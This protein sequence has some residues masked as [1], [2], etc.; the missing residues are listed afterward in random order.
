MNSK[1]INLTQGSAEWLDFRKTKITATD[2][3]IIMGLNPWKTPL[4]LWEEKL[5]LR[6]PQVI[7]DKMRDGSLMEEEARNYIN[8]A[9]PY[10]LQPVVLVSD[11][12][13]FM[14]ASLD[15]YHAKDFGK[16]VEIKCGKSS[17]EL[18][19][20]GEIP[21]Y[22]M[23]QLQK[24][25]FVSGISTISYFSYRSGIDN[26]EIIVSRDDAFIEKMIE[27]EKEFYRCMMDFTPPPATDRD[28][29]T[30]DSRD[31]RLHTEVWKST[32]AQIK[33]LEAKEEALRKELIAM[34]D[35]KSSQGNGVRV[36]KSIRKGNIQYKNIK[37]LENL[38]L[39]IYRA[40]PV[41]FYRITENE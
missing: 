14:M 28:Y 32:K 7:N 22:Y 10:N 13:H 26:V 12:Y 39:E 19:L 18:A 8:S 5:G 30:I 40:K 17:H 35:G 27:A 9:S 24:Q 2:T 34:C 4:M 23:S 25:M 16:I 41:E 21:P 31:W 3:G 11:A 38:D 33:L 6:E 1:I 37:E 29:I 20:K 36:S 15:G